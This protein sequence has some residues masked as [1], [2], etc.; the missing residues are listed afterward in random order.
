MKCQAV[1]TSVSKQY[2]CI[3]IAHSGHY[4]FQHVSLRHAFKYPMVCSLCI[5]LAIFFFSWNAK[6]RVHQSWNAP[7]LWHEYSMVHL[8]IQVLLY[9]SACSHVF[10]QGLTVQMCTYSPNESSGAGQRNCI[11]TEA[12]C[13]R[14]IESKHIEIDKNWKT[15][16]ERC[17]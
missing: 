11:G 3:I 12:K 16:R 6:N 15:E 13:D 2:T 10:W 5:Y 4:M 14:R 9:Q 17:L 8:S 7:Q 1:L